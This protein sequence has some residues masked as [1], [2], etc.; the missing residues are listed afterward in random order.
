M[1][2]FTLVGSGVHLAGAAPGLVSGERLIVGGD[3]RGSMSAGLSTYP[4]GLVHLPGRERAILYV[5]AGRFSHEPGLFAH[6]WHFTAEGPVL[7][8]PVKVRYPFDTD[9]LRVA[10]PSGLI[11][12][13]R[14]GTVY[15]FWILDGAL[16][17]TRL[18]VSRNEFVPV[19]ARPIPLGSLPG[20]APSP[21]TNADGR[22]VER[23]G[24]IERDDGSLL[25]VLSVP[26]PTVY[27]P[28]G[29]QGRRDPNFD[30]YDGRGLWRG[31]LPRV[32]LF[33][34]SLP[35][36]EADVAGIADLRQVSPTQ[37]EA[38]FSHGSLAF[39]DL[40]RGVGADLVTG[41][42]LGIFYHYRLPAGDT[43]PWPPASLVRGTDGRAVRNDFVWT[44]PVAVPGPHGR[45][46]DI[47]AGGEGG[48]QHYRFDRFAADGAPVYAGPYPLPVENALF[49][50]GSLP[51]INSVDWDGDG[52]TDLV[53][54][55]SE[56]RIL[57]FRN[58]GTN[59]KPD[60]RP[61]EAL[62]AG[63]ETIHI[64]PGYA[65]L[66][67]PDE[68]RWAYVSPVVVDWDG[69]GRP[70]ILSS[71]A[72]A[73]HY[74]FR[75]I[76]TPTSPRLAAAA[77]LFCDG[78]DIHGTWRVRPG[79]ARWG[80]GTAYVALDSDDEFRLYWRIDDTHLR[81]GGKLRMEDGSVIGAN[82]IH[83][84]G[85]GRTKFTLADW[86]GDGVMDILVGTPRHGSVPN[87]R[88]GLPQALGLPGAAVL[89][90]RNTGTDAEPKFAFPRVL[91]FR[92]RLVF[93][94][95]HACSLALT[96]L[97]EPGGPHLLV[98]DEEG[99]IHYFAR[100]DI[101]WGP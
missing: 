14:D 22:A 16:I 1:L 67:G 48:L 5:A 8:E 29:F 28:A 19:A 33:A 30:P 12:Q 49:Y 70:D 9:D 32:F 31:G 88:T 11:F 61:G 94:G 91:H 100:E 92:G 4:L 60:F 59:N 56:G 62:A 99:R 66:Q 64:Q 95:Q 34:G 90:L 86:D 23:L 75:N 77:P 36:P 65:A 97:G 96:D 40:G 26:D 27:L 21:R 63:G 7:G 89:W 35:G 39:P 73:M 93:F 20:A 17:R 3:R 2:L 57:F 6:D 41:S 87:P 53:V 43:E 83:A 45:L 42:Y 76:G 46:S 10:P 69:D 15:G 18:E 81:D 82:F 101:S 72:R 71:D 37:R 24:I 55:N 79:A 78:L 68:A 74:L 80:D 58:H 98:G 51:V 85:T 44:S 47:V 38:L 50:T 84:G 52:V 25:V 54:G 13:T